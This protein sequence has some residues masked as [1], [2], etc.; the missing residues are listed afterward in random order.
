M[1]GVVIAVTACHTQIR[2]PSTIFLRPTSF[3][4]P[5]LT[6][7]DGELRIQELGLL[8]EH[9]PPLQPELLVAQATALGLEPVPGV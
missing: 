7:L 4:T 3:L 9:L 1:R 5:P 6:D 8:H 2:N